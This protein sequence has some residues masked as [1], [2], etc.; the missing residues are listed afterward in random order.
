MQDANNCPK[1]KRNNLTK[2]SLRATKNF[3]RANFIILFFTGLH[4]VEASQE[5]SEP[6][7][8]ICERTTTVI[9]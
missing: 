7:Y 1:Q 5:S 8:F 3:L 2:K 6:K 9:K 4:L